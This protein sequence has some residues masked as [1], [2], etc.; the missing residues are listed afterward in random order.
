MSITSSLD[1]LTSLPVSGHPPSSS[2]RR[3]LRDNSSFTAAF[4]VLSQLGNSG[5]ADGSA[6]SHGSH[7]SNIVGQ[8]G[9]SG[10]VNA[11]NWSS[12]GSL[13]ASGSDDTRICLWKIGAE[14]DE[15]ENVHPAHGRTASERRQFV[16]QFPGLGMGLQTM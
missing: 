11:L 6:Y 9:H 4:D 14:L 2:S 8:Y 12:D 3:I 7:S 5:P 13:L 1:R 15:Q 10:C 16:K